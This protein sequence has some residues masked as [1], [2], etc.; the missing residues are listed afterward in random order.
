MQQLVTW[1]TFF[2]TVNY[3]SMGSLAVAL[4]KDGQTR[5]HGTQGL[6]YGGPLLAAVAVVFI[7]QNALGVV[8]PLLVRRE[9]L[10]AFRRMLRC[11]GV[12]AGGEAVTEDGC[13]MPVG[14]YSVAPPMM[15][16]ALLPLLGAWV[17]FLCWSR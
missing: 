5:Q 12:L 9:V 17:W 14:L 10:G 8:V 11:E 16:V 7:V 1:F 13:C 2:A 6:Q 4:T 3:A 15:A